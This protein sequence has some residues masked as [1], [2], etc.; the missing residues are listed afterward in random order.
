MVMLEGPEIE[1]NYGAMQGFE[2]TFDIEC[3]HLMLPKIIMKIL[4][5]GFYLICREK[6]MI[7]GGFD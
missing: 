6:K 3:V 2:S 1:H 5:P 7:N 4:L